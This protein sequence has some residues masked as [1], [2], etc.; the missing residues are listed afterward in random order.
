MIRAYNK[1]MHP[2]RSYPGKLALKKI[3]LIQKDT[4]GKWTPNWEWLYVMKK[5][6]SGGALIL[7]EIDGNALPNPVNS[8]FV[9]KYYT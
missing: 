1:K 6:F 2:W 5:V 8:D 9:K 3:L 7:S 4:R